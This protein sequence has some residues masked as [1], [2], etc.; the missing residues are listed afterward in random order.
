MSG[1]KRTGRAVTLILKR[2]ALT[3][4]RRDVMSASSEKSSSKGCLLKMMKKVPLPWISK[5][6]R[7]KRRR[8]S[9]RVSHLNRT[10]SG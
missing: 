3:L 10:R 6:G 1:L 4:F 2:T 8:K 5:S 9:A 7:R